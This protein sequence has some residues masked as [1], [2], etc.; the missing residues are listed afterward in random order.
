MLLGMIRRDQPE[1]VVAEAGASPLEPYNGEVVLQELR[2]AVKCTVLCASDPYAVAGVIL[3]FGYEPDLVAGIATN[4][5]SG[6]DLVKKLTGQAGFSFLRH[7]PSEEGFA[8]IR[9]RLGI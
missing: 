4:T 3:G 1:V 8:V 7:D 9:D 2:E 6:V 5:T